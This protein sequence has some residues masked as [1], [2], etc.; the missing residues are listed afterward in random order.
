MYPLVTAHLR[1]RAAA[2][3]AGQFEELAAAY[4]YP[5]PVFLHESRMIVRTPGEVEAMLRLLREALEAR[6]VVS[7]Q[8]TICAMDLPQGGRFRVWVDWHEVART[9]EGCRVS[10]ALYF[11]RV[12]PEGV[13]TEMVHYSRLSTPELNDQFAALALSA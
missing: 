12:A 9:P 4:A 5:L 11:C 10:S 8:P 13:R 7:I 2:L 3:M 1:R 6:G